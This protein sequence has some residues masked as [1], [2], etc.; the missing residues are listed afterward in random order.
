MEELSFEDM[1]QYLLN[2]NSKIIH[3]VWF[4][5]IPNKREA[6]KTYKKL[7]V[8]RDSWI[9]KNPKWFYV[10]WN[11]EKCEKLVKHFYPQH[12][13]MY[14]KYPYII[15][16]CDAVRYFILHRYGGLYAD[17]DYFCN[18]PWDEVIKKYPD[19]IYVVETPN[20]TG[21]D[22]VHV[23]NSLMYSVVK[24]HPYWNSIFIEME[25]KKN[26][27][28]YYT[29][30]HITIMMTTGPSIINR[31]FNK[32]K[33]RYKLNHYP[34]K[35]FHPYGVTDDAKTLSNCNKEQDVYAYHIQN[36][37]WHKKD[38]VILNFIYQEYKI[39]LVIIFLLII[40]LLFKK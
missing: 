11:L 28:Y 38:T 19:D 39:I 1:D 7:K 17:M 27:S 35:L 30:R 12:L 33:Y 31:I 37:C 8:Y 10:S 25:L 6:A 9:N 22:K 21:N 14:K 24:N 18:K 32:Y 16:K 5:T 23:S 29:S 15:Q 36:G 2:Q 26:S 3:Q 34:F 40:P 4:G 13:E 20:N